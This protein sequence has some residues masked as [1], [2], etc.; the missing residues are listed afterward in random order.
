MTNIKEVVVGILV[1][2]LVVFLIVTLYMVVSDQVVA[3][4]NDAVN[5]VD[6]TLREVNEILD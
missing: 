6:D 5:I 4:W 1:F 2:L 3:W